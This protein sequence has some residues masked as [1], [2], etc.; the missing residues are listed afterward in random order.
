MVVNGRQTMTYV[1]SF[2]D[3]KGVPDVT[4][5]PLTTTIVTYDKIAS[6][7]STIDEVSETG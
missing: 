1:M 6:G 5:P 4:K 7:Y 2:A 3:V